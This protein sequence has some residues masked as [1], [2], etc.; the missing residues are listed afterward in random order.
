MLNR[1][2]R[3]R[4]VLAAALLFG[5]RLAVGPNLQHSAAD[6]ERQRCRALLTEEPSGGGQTAYYQEHATNGQRGR[7]FWP[8]YDQY[9][10]E[11]RKVNDTRFGLIKQYA[12]VY[13]TMTA[14]QADSIVSCWPRPTRPSSAC[15]CSICRGSS[16]PCRARRQRCLCSLI[17]DW[18][19]WP[20]CRW[21]PSYRRSSHSKTHCSAQEPVCS[22]SLEIVL[23]TLRRRNTAIPPQ[24]TNLLWIR[25]LPRIKE[26]TLW[27]FGRLDG[28]HSD[29]GCGKI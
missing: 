6:G 12:K 4:L 19:T 21:P 29:G 28:L 11:V 5:K 23:T 1:S 17:G 10:A 27:L 7:R 8:L 13:Q 9:A 25:H 2:V 3:Q 15:E 14:D 22:R 24:L 18:T 16:R 26:G 20:T